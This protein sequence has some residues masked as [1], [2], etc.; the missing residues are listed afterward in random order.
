M[1]PP[2]NWFFPCSCQTS[3]RP[4]VLTYPFAKIVYLELVIPYV[5]KDPVYPPADSPN[6]MY[7]TATLSYTYQLARNLRLLA[8]YTYDLQAEGSRVVIGT[9]GGF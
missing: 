3:L 1:E 9:I 4:K 5:E 8:E 2:I 6:Y 7:E